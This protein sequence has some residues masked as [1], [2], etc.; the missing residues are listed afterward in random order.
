MIND[1]AQLL[2]A[3]GMR[4]APAGVEWDA[5]K[6]GRHLAVRAIEQIATPGAVAVDPAPSEPMLYFFVPPGSAADWDVPETTALGRNS[7]VVLPPSHKEEPPGP[8]WLLAQRHGL[9]RT[10]ILRQ[11]LEAVR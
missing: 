3:A 5:V 11:A 10:A 6:V 9:T 1:A 7:H 4:L 8:Y 2:S